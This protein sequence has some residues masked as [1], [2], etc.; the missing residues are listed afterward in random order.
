MNQ[1]PYL[2][3]LSV[4]PQTPR[5][6]AVADTILHDLGHITPTQYIWNT[7]HGALTY[8]PAPASHL[9]LPNPLADRSPCSPGPIDIGDGNDGPAGL[10]VIPSRF[11]SDSSDSSSDCSDPDHRSGIILNPFVSNYQ[12]LGETPIKWN[13][14]EPADMARHVLDGAGF[15]ANM[16]APATNPPA[17]TLRIEFYFVDQPGAQW[18]WEPILVKKARPIRVVDLFHEIHRY[19]QRQ[20][21]YPEW[22]VINSYG[23]R[24]SRI[25]AKSWRE[26]VASQLDTEAQ[27]R[28]FHGGLKRVDCL[29]SAKTFAGLWVEDSRVMLGL[30]T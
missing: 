20:L 24:N 27:S 4:V 11:S 19:F 13:V 9:L 8:T 16:G 22:D 14:S 7:P 2:A 25:V 21:T 3:Q 12:P 5:Q 30:R 15:L 10:G 18:N 6:N 1:T 17:N 28:V 26:R 23:K 29:G